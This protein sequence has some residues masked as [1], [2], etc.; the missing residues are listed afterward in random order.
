MSRFYTSDSLLPAATYAGVRSDVIKR[1]EH[2]RHTVSCHQPH[3]RSKI[4]LSRILTIISPKLL[5]QLKMAMLAA[6]MM[7]EAS[8]LTCGNTCKGYIAVAA[9][10][11]GN[12]HALM[13]RV[14]GEFVV[15]QSNMRNSRGHTGVTMYR[16]TAITGIQQPCQTPPMITLRPQ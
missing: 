14:V 1:A 2:T 12:D 5:G 3:I 6:A 15:R 4:Q 9:I 11:S 7:V 13:P 10:I 8:R 16:G